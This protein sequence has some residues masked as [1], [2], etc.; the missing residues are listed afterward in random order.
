MKFIEQLNFVFKLNIFSECIS[1]FQ[2][3]ESIVL[4]S[5]KYIG[6]CCI[7]SFAKLYRH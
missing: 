3:V 5:L 4:R 7:V 6:V 2:Q 1:I